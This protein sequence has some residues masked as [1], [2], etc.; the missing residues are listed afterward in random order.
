[1]EYFKKASFGTEPPLS[2]ESNWMVLAQT[3]KKKDKDFERQHLS[4]IIF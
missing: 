2:G 1:L 4:G 3:V